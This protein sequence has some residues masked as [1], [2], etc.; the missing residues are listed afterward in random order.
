[1]D[2]LV[3]TARTLGTVRLPSKLVEPTGA[4]ETVRNARGS[5]LNALGLICVPLSLV[6][7]DCLMNC[8]ID[9]ARGVKQSLVRS[10]P[11]S[12]AAFWIFHMRSACRQAA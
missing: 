8:R 1:M 6:Y 2:G 9:F 10:K 11:R 5:I 12:R 4:Q 7:H 3:D